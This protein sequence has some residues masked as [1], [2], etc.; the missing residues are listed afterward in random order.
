MN[1]PFQIAANG[2]WLYHVIV[3]LIVRP[4]IKPYCSSNANESSTVLFKLLTN[5]DVHFINR[6]FFFYDN[7]ASPYE[8]RTSFSPH[9]N[10]R[11]KLQQ[12][13][14]RRM[15]LSPHCDL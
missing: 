9:C 7:P 13:D 5:K 10:P 1:I 15:S 14:E 8:K 2:V 11:R 6:F 3:Q 12:C 4:P